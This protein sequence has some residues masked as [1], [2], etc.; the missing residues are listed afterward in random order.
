MAR[1]RLIVWLVLITGTAAISPVPASA[2]P[3][4]PPGFILTASNGYSIHALA[5]DGDRFGKPDVLIL[6]VGRSDEGATY[7]VRKGV[8]VT[9]STISASLGD[10]G[11]ID[12]HFAPSGETRHQTSS[13]DSHPIEFDSGFYEGRIDFIGE[14][15]YT[16]AHRERARGE[17]K[18]AASLICG[19]S[20]DEGIGGYSPGA[21][22][23]V[24]REWAG[25]GVELEVTKNSPSRPSRF[26]AEV[27]E[28]KQ[29][30]VVA[31]AVTA[32]A[33]PTAFSFDVPA[34]VATLKLPSP[35]N[36]SARFLPSGE[37]PGRLSGHAGVDFPGRSNVSLSGT[38]G[39]LQRWVQNPSHPFRLALPPNPH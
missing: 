11:S 12:L 6:F 3:I 33:K 31:R 35:F 2:A 37:G 13:C 15:G 32:E 8:A 4:T 10:L 19:S 29:G 34:Q 7:F 24:R 25:G 38:T 21:R 28:R 1:R 16:E 23:L 39:S 9:E 26:R 27:K 14:E 20:G 18:I 30:M 22:L 36:G 5:F 17:V